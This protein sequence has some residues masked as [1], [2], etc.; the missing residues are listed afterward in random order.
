MVSVKTGPKKE[1]KQVVPDYLIY[2]M[3][4]GIPVY[5]RGYKDVL[6]KTKTLEEIMAYR[7]LPWFIINLL[8]DYF[9]PIFGKKYWVWSGEGGL[10]VGHRSN[11]SLDFVILP[12]SAFS[13]KKAKNKYIDTPPLVVIEVD[14]KADIEDLPFTGTEYVQKKNQELIDFGV[15]EV[16][17]FFTQTEKVMVARPNQ[18]WLTV[19]WKDTIEIMSH[20]FSLQNII[21][22]SE[23]P[24]ITE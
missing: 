7:D 24:T 8:K 11:P 23:V 1:E 20:P 10:H 3:L 18:P 6:N 16:V 17:W 14:T 13:Y 19:D 12:K 5:Y 9:Q 22:E 4:N 15:A 2:E 21:K